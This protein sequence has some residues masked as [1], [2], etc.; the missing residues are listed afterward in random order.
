MNKYLLIFI[1]IFYI[2][3][4]CYLTYLITRTKYEKNWWWGIPTI[5]IIFSLG[6]CLICSII[7]KFI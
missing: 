7:D 4:A 5:I 2:Y 6:V 3:A 1:A